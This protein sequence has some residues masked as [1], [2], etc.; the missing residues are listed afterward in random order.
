MIYYGEDN[1]YCL[2]RASHLVV[3]EEKSDNGDNNNKQYNK[4]KETN[5]KDWHAD[6]INLREKHSIIVRIN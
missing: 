6:C 4:K 2:V 1:N 5:R 3:Y